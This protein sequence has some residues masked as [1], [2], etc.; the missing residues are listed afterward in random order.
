MCVYGPCS[1][2]DDVEPLDEGLARKV[3]SQQALVEDLM[4]KVAERRKRVPEQVKMLLDDALRRQAA[5]ADRIEFESDDEKDDASEEM[6]DGMQ[7]PFS[8]MEKKKRKKS[9]AYGL[10]LGLVLTNHLILW[11]NCYSEIGENGSRFSGIHV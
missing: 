11:C 7:N 9:H 1:I 8:G 3:Q 5:L 6:D 2:L 10:F 4:L